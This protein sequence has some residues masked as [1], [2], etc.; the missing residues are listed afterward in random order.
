MHSSRLKLIAI[1]NG[2]HLHLYEAKGLKI[3]NKLKECPLLIHGHHMEKNK[4]TFQKGSGPASA[5]EPQTTSKELDHHDAAKTLAHILEE[6]LQNNHDFVGVA[7]AAEPRMLGFI[8]QNLS[9]NLKKKVL[10]EVVKDLIHQG[11]P[12]IEKAFFSE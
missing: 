6:E 10:K 7:I 12:S 4:G 9:E 2:E 1:A 5:F 3:T 8:R 11:I